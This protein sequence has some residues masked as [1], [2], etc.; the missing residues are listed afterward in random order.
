VEN[1]IRPIFFPLLDPRGIEMLLKK[2]KD[3]MG[4]TNGNER[5]RQVHENAENSTSNWELLLPLASQTL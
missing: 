1:L 3:C 4:G 2:K 5:G